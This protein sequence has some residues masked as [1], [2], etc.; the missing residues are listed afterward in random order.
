MTKHANK[1]FALFVPPPDDPDF[2]HVRD[3]LMST[4][5]RAVMQQ[6]RKCAA[7]CGISVFETYA[8]VSPDPDKPGFVTITA[9]PLAVVVKDH[10][11][12]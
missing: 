7:A 1:R 10:D 3:Y 6:R 8:T 11:K 2:V 12:R 5:Q 4:V 9:Y